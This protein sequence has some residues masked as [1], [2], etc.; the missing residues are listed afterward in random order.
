MNLLILGLNGKRLKDFDLTDIFNATM[1][2]MFH[3][4]MRSRAFKSI[5]ILVIVLTMTQV[6]FAQAMAVNHDLHERLHPNAN[7]PLHHCLAT[8]IEASGCDLTQVEISCVT[9]SY[10]QELPVLLP[11]T[12]WQVFASTQGKASLASCPPHAP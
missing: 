3:V 2:D 12:P 6:L 8:I 10:E 1:D 4:S 5:R 7:S 9:V 11:E